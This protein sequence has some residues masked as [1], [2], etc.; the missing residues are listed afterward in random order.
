M[1][2]VPPSKQNDSYW[3]MH[4]FLQYIIYE[5]ASVSLEKRMI[6]NKLVYLSSVHEEA[7]ASLA[8]MMLHTEIRMT[9]F[10]NQYRI[11]EE[12][13]AFLANTMIQTEIRMTSFSTEFTKKPVPP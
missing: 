9:S 13:S 2:Q 10:S 6:H 11:H 8:N 4:V 1:K 3:N 5:E 12:A 7:S